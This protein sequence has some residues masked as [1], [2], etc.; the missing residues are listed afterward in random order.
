MS[1]G[2]VYIT[3]SDEYLY[4]EAVESAS[5]VRSV[6]PN[7]DICVVTDTQ[8]TPDI[9]DRTITVE[10]LEGGFA[11][12]VRHMNK[13]PFD[14]TVYLDTDTYV[15][16][17]IAELFDLLSNYD[18]AAA[19]APVRQ[20]PTPHRRINYN[21]EVPDSYPD[22]NA[23]V[24]VFRSSNEVDGFLK[25]W[26][27]A[28]QYYREEEN[29]VRDQYSFRE[30]LYQSDVDFHTLMPEYNCRIVFPG[31]VGHKVKI[32]HGRHDDIESVTRKLNRHPRPR[33]HYSDWSGFNVDEEV[34]NSNIA[35]RTVG[36]LYRNGIIETLE[37]GVSK[38]KKWVDFETD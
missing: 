11:D 24:I 16:G 1:R 14:E 38:T 26:W 36:Y 12:K 33:V 19:Q 28:Y 9:F 31:Y 30:V 13:S 5:S 2:V 21:S 22:Y 29:I 35:L 37:R 18:V 23:G 10:C 15:L 32:A 34:N 27:D 25:R 8:N 4:E 3:D 7:I 20:L 17:N 6:M